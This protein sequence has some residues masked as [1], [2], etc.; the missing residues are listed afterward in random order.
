[1]KKL[2]VTLLVALTTNYFAQDW[3][4][5]LEQPGANFYTVQSAFNNYFT[6]H[7]PEE[8]GKGYKQFKR[9]EHF[10][11][12][13]VYP[14]GDLTL[15]TQNMKNFELYLQTNSTQKVINPNMLAST[16]WT[17]IGPFGALS[18]S[19][20]GQLLKSGRLNFI[21]IHPAGSNT[22]FV[23]APAGGLWKSTNGGLTWTTNTDYLTVIGCSDL[24]I[25]PSNHNI[26]YLATGDG[27]AGDTYSTGVLKSTDGG[28]TW[29]A[30]GL[31][32]TVN[33]GR[34]IR[35]LAINP[36]NP[37]IIYAATNAG[38]Y[39]TANGGT[40]WNAVIGTGSFHDIEFKPTNPNVVY[41][42]G[43]TFYRSTNGGTTFTAMTAAG[44]P[45]ATNLS[46][47][48]IAVTP[49]DTNYVYVLAGQNAANSYGFFGF[50]RST[51][52]ATNFST[53]ATTPNLLGWSSTGGDNGGQAWY[54]LCVAASPL[55]KDEVVTGGVNVWRT[56]NG[57]TNWTIFGHWTGTGAPFT[58]ADHH[59]LEYDAA[60]T[61]FNSND[62]TVY[63]RTATN[64]QEISGL[65]NISQ[66]YKIGTSGLT[67]NFWITGHQDNGTSY[68]NGTTYAARMGGDGMD[69][70][71]D[72]TNNA[73]MFASYYS[74]SFRYSTNTGGT[75]ST[76]TGISGT[77]NWVS[78]WK[79]DPANANNVWAARQQMFRSTNK[80]VS[81][82]MTTGTMTGTSTIV[83]FAVAPTNN[84][85]VYVIKG[86]ALWKTTDG[87]ATWT[88]I[89]G[90]VPTGSGAPT[91]ITVSPTDANKLWVTLSGYSA[92]NKVFLSTNG[93]TTWTN[94][95]SNLPNL[96]ANCS[97]YQVGSN[98]M[99]YV[100]MD[101]G[102][103]YRDNTMTTWTL[104]N[105]GLPNVPVSDMEISP[106]DPTKL[107]AATY[108]RGVWKVDVIS[109][110]PPVS[111]FSVAAAGLCTG[112]N[113]VFN[114]QSTN[115]PIS[116]SWSVTPSSGVTINTS[117]SKNP[118]VNF[119]TGGTYVVSL[120]ASNGV[121]PGNVSTQTITVNSTPTVTIAN[122]TQSVCAGTPVTFTAS[123]AATYNWTGGG[124]TGSA[125][126]YTPTAPTSYTVT[127]NNGS[128]SSTAIA[129]VA[130]NTT[131]IVA[132]A[133]LNSI[134]LG[135]STNLTATGA[136]TYSWSTSA[137]TA[138]ISVNP[139]VTTT[140]SVTGTGSNGCKSTMVK[141]LSVNP[142]P[143]LNT[144]TSSSVVCIGSNANLIVSGAST[145]TWMPGTIIGSSVTA[146]PS[147][148]TTYTVIGTDANGCTNTSTRSLTV[149][150]LPS[151]NAVASSTSICTGQS[152]TLTAS[153]AASYTWMPGSIT[154]NPIAITPGATTNYTLLGASAAGCI[155]SA[156]RNIV[157]NP[158]PIVSV[159]NPNQSICSGNTVTFNASGASTYVWTNGGGTSSVATYTPS[160]TTSYTVTG[161]NG[162]CSS[163]AIVN[164]TV[165]ATPTVVVSNA[166]Q[167]ICSGNSVTFNASGASAYV[168]TNS[169]GTGANASYSPTTNSTYTVTGSNGTCSSNA[170]VNVT[171]SPTPSV[172]IANANQVICS[173]SSVT[174]NAGGATNYSWSNGGGSSAAATYTPASSSTYT[175][176]G[177]TGTCSGF[178]VASVSVSAC[179]GINEAALA[180]NVF[181]AYPNPTTGKLNISTI[182]HFNTE[183]SYELVDVLGKVHAKQKVTFDSH[184][185]TESIDMSELNDGVY[186]IKITTGN[187]KPEIVK[188]IKN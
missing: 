34:L 188:V 31:A 102:V 147:V 161:S 29:V 152:T 135:S 63:R 154:G 41:V 128:C 155:G 73:N 110:A 141:T 153:G 173:G 10:M 170:I 162:S 18:G 107:V 127:G 175:V 176:T 134:C 129:N 85:I 16:T 51:N 13:R 11:E 169:G 49:A 28:L 114:D 120:V 39:R 1:M 6:T 183:I 61:L 98:D 5:M 47:M 35:K 58:H 27:D 115:A 163:S 3:A 30:T 93:G 62:G 26:M 43:T 8:K 95:T 138:S 15:P 145:Y 79:Q 117:A 109:A 186:F 130:I 136:I 64:W 48:A 180:E 83:E 140:Y 132:V 121:G 139:T 14:T 89:T 105:T 111:S 17:P 146:T 112:Q 9:W 94:Y 22:L 24:V 40:T 157:V 46:R 160:G 68:W 182:R 179:T 74:G 165:N 118:T 156:T 181:V 81:F 12:P 4:G 87:G 150:P 158:N 144:S 131:P 174:F 60:G 122:A 148:N 70:F 54:D 52:G 172:T 77:G 72:R 82:A 53:T 36:N 84:Q 167:T 92:G 71:I 137:T 23:G 59:D 166:N 149:N 187:S 124:G 177:T 32:Y 56:T 108:G 44:L 101:V 116:W 80:G 126:T 45:A 76:P 55:N 37:Q 100:G 88:N 69:C 50:Y 159:T 104:Y 86:T 184:N 97:V 42:A 65:M 90:T 2:Y 142:L 185:K 66:I 119:S 19:A 33:Q 91:F 78:P 57:G 20:G 99:V 168:W 103:Y 113:V 96:P 38:V 178:A 106:A 171:L 164:V 123:G 7:D 75:W 151:V 125:A 67:P 21:T 25:D 133:G 143:T